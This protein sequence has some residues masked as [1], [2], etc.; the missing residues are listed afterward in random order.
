MYGDGVYRE[1]SG[2]WYVP[3]YANIRSE[4]AWEDAEIVILVAEQPLLYSGANRGSYSWSENYDSYYLWKNFV[5][6]RKKLM[7]SKQR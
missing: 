4:K 5:Q 7:A 6:N 3:G 2:D 1:E